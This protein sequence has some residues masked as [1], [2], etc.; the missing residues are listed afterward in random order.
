MYT[1]GQITGLTRCPKCATQLQD[2]RELMYASRQLTDQ[3]LTDNGF[4]PERVIGPDGL[5]IKHRKRIPLST[6]DGTLTFSHKDDV[7]W[8][9]VVEC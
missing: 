4:V 9:R 5:P 8:D 7:V 1:T 6:C 3:R 2:L